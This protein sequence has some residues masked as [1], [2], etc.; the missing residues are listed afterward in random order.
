MKKNRRASLS[1]RQLYRA[2]WQTAGT[3]FYDRERL[4]AWGTWEHRFDRRIK[5][6]QSAI[7]FAEQ[8]LA[9]L[10]DP[11]TKLTVVAHAAQESQ[12]TDDAAAS[13]SGP[14]NVLA[15]VSPSNIGYL[16]ILGFSDRD[17]VTDVQKASELLAGC[18][19]IILDLRYNQGGNRDAALTC[20]EVFVRSGVVA[21][22]EER[23]VDGVL[24]RRISL[25]PQ[26]CVWTDELPDGQTV[27]ETYKRLPPVL[28]GKPLVVLLSGITASAAEILAMAAII[29]GMQGLC[30]SVGRTSLGKGIAQT[31]DIDIL[32]KVKLRISCGRN[33][34]PGDEWLGDGKGDPDGIEPDIVVVDDQGPQALAVAAGEI[35]RMLD[36]LKQEES[37]DAKPAS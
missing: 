34:G 22:I 10:Q 20:C 33:L 19:G 6:D 16:R 31:D 3:I 28:A 13:D 15:S 18:S 1:G 24:R 4:A 35:R 37:P 30:V 9:S 17:V 21:T 29:H 2:I 32:G 7:A 26:V 36:E 5:D 8:M 12:S 14:S 11:Y 27:S 25:T 23:R